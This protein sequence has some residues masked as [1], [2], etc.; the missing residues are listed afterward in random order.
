MQLYTL[1]TPTCFIS[2]TFL[3]QILHIFVFEGFLEGEIYIEIVLK[4]PPKLNNIYFYTF[5]FH[6]LRR[7]SSK[8]YQLPPVMALAGA[9]DK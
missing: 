3:F 6:V 8:F 7:S 2:E 9:T 5:H 4:P 1:S